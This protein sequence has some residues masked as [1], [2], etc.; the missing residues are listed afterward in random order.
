MDLESD[1]EDMNPKQS[2]WVA[3]FISF[4]FFG[5]LLSTVQNHFVCHRL[6]FA[7]FENLK[8]IL[9]TVHIE[10]DADAIFRPPPS[11]TTIWAPSKI[12]NNQPRQL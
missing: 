7:S 5:L 6:Y 9:F 1:A 8:Q 4:C 3:S 11:K 2:V 10:E 12:Q